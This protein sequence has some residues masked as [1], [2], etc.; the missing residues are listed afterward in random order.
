MVTD[1]EENDVTKVGRIG[2][3]KAHVMDGR[4]YKDHSSGT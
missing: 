1:S 2:V 3:L 4:P